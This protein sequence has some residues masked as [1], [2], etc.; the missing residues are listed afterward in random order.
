MQDQY[1]LLLIKL[2]LEESFQSFETVVRMEYF[3]ETLFKESWI[4]NI[5]MVMTVH[6]IQYNKRFHTFFA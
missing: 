2:K 6:S 3:K 1:T 5:F 4:R